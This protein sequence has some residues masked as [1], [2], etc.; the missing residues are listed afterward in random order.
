MVCFCRADSLWESESLLGSLQHDDLYRERCRT[1][2]LLCHGKRPGRFEVFRF[3]AFFLRPAP[4]SLSFCAFL[5]ISFS[6]T[7]HMHS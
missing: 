1:V 5:P 3:A 4:R 6:K 2:Y 7:L